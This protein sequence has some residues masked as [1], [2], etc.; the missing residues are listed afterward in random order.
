MFYITSWYLAQFTCQPLVSP[1]LASNQQ[2]HDGKTE[3][4]VNF[5]GIF[6][7]I[8]YYLFS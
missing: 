8:K 6:H 3:N 4:N 7:Q 2:L 5:K 1:I